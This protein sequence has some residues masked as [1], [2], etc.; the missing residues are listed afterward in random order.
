MAQ[1]V[2][3]TL[4]LA[5]ALFAIAP[6]AATAQVTLTSPGGRVFSFSAD[7]SLQSSGME[8]LYAP[9]YQLQVNGSSYSGGSPTMSADGRTATFPAVSIGALVAQRIVY[10]PAT[11]T[12]DF[13]RFLD[14]ISNSGGSPMS[15]MVTL[16]TTLESFGFGF[17]TV[18]VTASSSGD[19]TVGTDDDWFSLNPGPSPFGGSNPLVA[20]VLQGP[21]AMVRATSETGGAGGGPFGGDGAVW[22]FNVTVPGGGRAAILT[23]A[24][25]KASS[26]MAGVTSDVTTLV[27]TPD[28]VMVGLDTYLDAIV[29]FQEDTPGAPRI[30]FAGP[31]MANEGDAVGMAATVTDP[32]GATPTWT[33]DLDGDGTFGDMPGVT[34]YTVP[35]GTTDGPGLIRVGIEATNGTGTSQRYHTIQIANVAPAIAPPLPS[36]MT[37]NGANYGYQIV[38]HDPA[39]TLDPLHYA[40]TSCPGSM[41]VSDTGFVSW[42]PSDM[43]VTMPMMPKHVTITVDDGDM[44]I[45]PLTWDLTVLSDHPPSRPSAIYP[46]GIAVADLM[47]RIVAGNA[48]DLD[49][50][51]L[52]YVFEVDVVDTFD[53]PDKMTSPAVPQTDGYTAWRPTT[54][55]QMGTPYFWRVKANDG[56]VDG[57]WA[58]TSFYTAGTPPPRDAGPPPD[59]S[60]H[61]GGSTTHDA[62][63]GGPPSRGC[64]STAT[65]APGG[66]AVAGLLF[67][68]VALVVAR[69]RR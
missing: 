4:L 57:E 34:D 59:G 15:A 31:S 41:T 35:A 45:T 10:V 69:R 49:G 53:S 67:G 28:D 68:L 19:T 7:G 54:P 33:W 64:C 16:S 42:T 12:H 48:T 14:I 6:T 63:H 2:L 37:T 26:D 5:A 38:A 60:A 18:A 61:D 25:E 20:P 17:G 56:M 3:P 30:R 13:A 23:F 62:G 44:G 11:G 1:R 32:S 39:A 8:F 36:S 66:G 65:G 46:S 40:C 22:S 50:D 47:P 9:G 43:D 52:T 24:V 27:S 51:P 58:M 55:L 21:A 29:N